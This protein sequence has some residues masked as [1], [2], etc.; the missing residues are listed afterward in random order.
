MKILLAHKYMYRGGGTATY[1]FAFM[2]E[3]KKRAQECIPFTVAYAQTD[4]DAYSEYY[5]SP[6]LGADQTHLRH[7]QV[8][9]WKALTLLG[10]ATYSLEARAKMSRLIQDT[11]PDLAYIHNI[12]NYISP[13]ILHAC[14]KAGLPI[15]MR[16]PDFNLMCAE[17]HFLHHGQVCTECMTHGFKRALR[18]NCLKN[19]R[20]ATLARVASM[21]MHKWLRVYDTV[22]LFVTPSAM[23]RDTLI[24]AGY[25]ADRIVHVR[26]FYNGQI[27]SGEPREGD[28]ILFFGRVAQEKGVDTLI[29][30]YARLRTDIRLVIA[31]GDTDGLIAKLQDLVSELGVKGVEFV[32]HKGRQELDELISGALFTVVPSRWYDNCPMAVLE[33]FAHGKTVIGSDIGGMPEMITDE[34]GMLFKPDVVDDLAEKMTSLLSDKDM[35][36]RMGRN[37]VR[38][39][40]DRFSASEHCDRLLGLFEALI[41]SSPHSR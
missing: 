2:E 11:Q 27:A 24:T 13:S 33:S 9:P 37:A 7:M 6:P 28:Y 31:G 12:Y 14:R 36:H 5:V 22:D 38:T 15:V 29:R 32:G 19:S 39:L 16:V 23:M 40:Q 4:I 25:P 17:L 21:Y 1:L 35:R 10:R 34:C 26:S 18:Y 41:E 3:M 20:A 8:T 30:A